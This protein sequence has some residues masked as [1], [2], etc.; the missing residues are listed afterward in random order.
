MEVLKEREREG[1]RE[2]GGG[3]T[4]MLWYPVYIM[5]MCVS[6]CAFNIHVACSKGCHE[7]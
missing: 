1:R 2:V 3:G 6:V 7:L 5:Y 4:H